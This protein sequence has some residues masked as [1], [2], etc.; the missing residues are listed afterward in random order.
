MKNKKIM[1]ILSGGCC[2]DAGAIEKDRRKFGG[3][4]IQV[5]SGVARN[6][7]KE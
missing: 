4:G 6:S 7:S 1:R 2:G 3:Q 5:A